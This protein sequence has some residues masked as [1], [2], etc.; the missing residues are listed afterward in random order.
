[1]AKLKKS[2]R[3]TLMIALA[4]VFIV[5]MGYALITSLVPLDMVNK[6]PALSDLS[7]DNYIRLFEEYPLG[8][9]YMNTIIVAVLT[10]AGNLTTALLGGYALAK[11]RF[12]GRKLLFT[13][14]L[15]LMMIPFQVLLTPLY[16]MVASLGWHNTIQGLVVPFMVNCL[17]I[18]MARQYYMSFP[19][20]L[21]EA[22]R[23]DGLGYIRSYFKIALPLSGPLVA[24][25]TILDFTSVWNAY[26]V[27]STFLARE[28]A[29]T[30]PVGLTTIKAANFIRANE[31]MAGVIL[32]SVP[33][34]I[35]FIIFQKWFVQGIAT[36]GLKE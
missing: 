10:L 16:I 33:I 6:V 29:F 34:L 15:A 25:L 35:F 20:E 22:S 2:L 9:W 19:D 36:A 11:F 24:S 30:L 8:T 7:L 1:M 31:T 4:L 18:F 32:L 12:R 21:I 3:Y 27:P 26:L 13:G 28:A 17:S 14:I 5:P 23:V